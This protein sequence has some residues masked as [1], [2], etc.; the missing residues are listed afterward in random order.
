MKEQRE[1]SCQQ[2]GFLNSDLELLCGDVLLMYVCMYYY[3]F[4]LFIFLHV[5]KY[6]RARR[7]LTA[8]YCVTVLHNPGKAAGFR[9]DIKLQTINN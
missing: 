6:G 2:T 5:A 3:L 7:P 4:Y 1:Y 8:C 9:H